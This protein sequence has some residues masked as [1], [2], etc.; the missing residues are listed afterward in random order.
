MLTK[1]NP[2]D[3]VGTNPCDHDNAL[4]A[5]SVLIRMCCT[6]H[7]VYFHVLLKNCNLILQDTSCC[8]LIQ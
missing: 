2:S 1:L 5:V 4:D 3:C 8:L 6:V 7:A